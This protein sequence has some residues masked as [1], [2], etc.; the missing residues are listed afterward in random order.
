MVED[1]ATMEA[2]EAAGAGVD[3]EPPARMTT[4]L[5]PNRLTT[6]N[7]A[8]SPAGRQLSNETSLVKSLRLAPGNAIRT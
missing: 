1:E 4:V 7:V 3:A 5:F 8:L 2:V 6:G